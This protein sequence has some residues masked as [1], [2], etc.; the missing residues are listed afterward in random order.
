MA[1]WTQEKWNQ[2]FI[3]NPKYKPL[4]EIFLSKIL[5][6]IRK[7]INP[8]PKKVFDIGCGTSDSVFQFAK[9]GFAVEGIDYSEVA[10]KNLQ[11]RI[12]NAHISGIKLI[13]ADLNDYVFNQESDIIFCHFVYAFIQKKDTFL[14]NIKNCMKENSVFILTTPVAYINVSYTPNDKTDIAVDFEETKE[15]L[16]NFFTTVEEYHHDYIGFRE[17]YLTFL[18]K[19]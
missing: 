12:E 17:D 5:E 16:S 3:T 11:E 19:K 2:I 9:R 4:N 7:E 8:A 14:Q 1:Q 13:Q 18:M 10:L 6:K 15:K